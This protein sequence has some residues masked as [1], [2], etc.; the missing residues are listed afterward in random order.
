MPYLCTNLTIY[1]IKETI[2]SLRPVRIYI[3]DKLVWDDDKDSL[4]NYEAILRLDLVVT[5]LKF[6]IVDHH[7][8]Y[9]AIKTKY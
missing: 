7:H 6:T 4:I 5:E 8:S 2:S 1:D 9:V 3:D